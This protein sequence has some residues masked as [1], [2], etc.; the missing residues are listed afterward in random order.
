MGLP[1]GTRARPA[2]RARPPL[3]FFALVVASAGFA[4]SPHM[5][6]ADGPG[7]PGELRVEPRIRLDGVTLGELLPAGRHATSLGKWN[8]GFA[9]FDRAEIRTQIV[10]RVP[11]VWRLRLAEDQD[12]HRLDVQYEIGTLDGRPGRLASTDGDDSEVRVGL[13]PIPPLVVS[14]A[15]D[16]PVIEGG[17]VLHLDLDSVRS[18]GQ[19]TGTLTITLNQL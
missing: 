9:N 4:Q 7:R 12:L 3:W 2:G 18:A 14:D 10:R 5:D 15:G 6:L 19:Y 1:A 17:V 11:T 16:G 8:G 13:R